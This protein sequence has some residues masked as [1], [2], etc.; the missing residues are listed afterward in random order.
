[1]FEIK[2]NFSKNN[3]M[4]VIDADETALRYNFFLGSL[5]LKKENKSIAIDW[6]WIPLIDFAICILI[7]CN[8]LLKKTQG[9]E[10]F[11]FTESDSKITFQKNG[12]KIKIITSFSDE[13]LEMDFE[14]FQKS[15]KEFYKDI[16]FE[17]VE[18]KQ[19]IKDNA[20]FIEYLKEAKKM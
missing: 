7:I 9:E 3:D 20:S 16:I 13:I 5:L 18:K 6:D 8:S 10:E 14:E 19:G 1:M 4:N 15:V 2:Y 11:E 12:D 17:V